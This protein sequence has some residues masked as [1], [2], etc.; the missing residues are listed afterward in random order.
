MNVI[1]ILNAKLFQENQNKMSS[2]DRESEQPE[3]DGTLRE[4][5]RINAMHRLLAELPSN[6]RVL[7]RSPYPIFLGPFVVCNMQSIILEEAR[8]A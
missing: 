8:V 3:N 5:P 4:V 2:K 6:R 7:K 1:E